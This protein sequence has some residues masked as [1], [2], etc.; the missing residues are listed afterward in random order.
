MKYETKRTLSFLIVGGYLFLGG[1]EYAVIFPTCLSYL[2]SLGAEDEYWLGFTV[3]AYS[4]SAAISGIIGGRLSDI[5]EH[6]TKTIAMVSIVL[7]MFGSLQYTI[8]YSVW[9]ILVSRLI[10]GCG[11]AAGSA[12]LAEVCRVTAVEERTPILAIC[13]ATRQLG[14]LVGPVFQIILEYFDFNVAGFQV[15]PLN[16]PGIFMAALWVVFGVMTYF[17]FYNLS[18]ELKAEKRLRRN[19]LPPIMNPTHSA[20]SRPVS[21]ASSRSPPHHDPP[22]SLLLPSSPISENSTNFPESVGHHLTA[23]RAISDCCFDEN[24]HASGGALGGNSG[25]ESS[26]VQSGVTQSHVR[27]QR[28]HS[29]SERF[30]TSLAQSGQKSTTGQVNLLNASG[31]TYTLESGNYLAEFLSDSF[32]L[33]LSMVFV[34]FFCQVGVETIVPVIMQDYFGYGEF[35]NSLVYMAGGAEALVVFFSVA[36]ISRYVRDTNL[37]LLGWVI[38]TAS[39]VWLIIFIPQFQ[40]HGTGSVAQVACFMAGL[41]MLYFGYAVASV[42]NTGLF[43]KCLSPNTQGLGQGL[44]R[45]VSYL[46]LIF[47]PTWSGAT[48]RRPYIFL[49]VPLGIILLKAIMLAVSF[50]D[51]RKI[52]NEHRDLRQ[53]SSS[54]ED[55]D[56]ERRPLIRR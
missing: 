13:N 18:A 45:M 56:E 7:M 37:M 8:G 38:L 3:S 26:G 39:H 50:R 31:V 22:K 12:M 27:R 53:S 36:I 33:M 25:I 16:A 11:T 42:A 48:I 46:G 52:E 28:L 32:I 6:H 40:E 4:F 35:Q 55:D 20:H 5:Y 10:C 34:L 19:N 49:G 54:D 44:R 21:V 15:T 1:C 24:S 29:I 9:N 30:L 14:I 51:L 41:V 47:G 17:M 23:Q 43:S 2:K